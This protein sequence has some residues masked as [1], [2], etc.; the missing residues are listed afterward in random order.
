[1]K[2][3]ALEL[4]DRDKMAILFFSFYKREIIF[5]TIFWVAWTRNQVPDRI[6]P[7]KFL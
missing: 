3:I 7:W 4:D 6:F 2:L 5:E 1:M